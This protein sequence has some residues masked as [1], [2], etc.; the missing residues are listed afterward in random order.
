MANRSSP[1][2]SKDVPTRDSRQTR[3]PVARRLI[4]CVIRFVALTVSLFCALSPHAARAGSVTASLTSQITIPQICTVSSYPSTINLG[5]TD[6]ITQDTNALFN[7]SNSITLSCSTGTNAAVSIGGNWYQQGSTWFRALF[8]GND[9]HGNGY[10]WYYNI[11]QPQTNG[12]CPATY[13]TIWGDGTHYATYTYTAQST[14]PV[15]LYLCF[16]VYA[17]S[18]YA[19]YGA[20]GTYTDTSVT[21]TV[22]P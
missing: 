16:A 22:S 6:G 21:I 9:G 10:S 17:G 12:I 4:P 3:L 2:L 13:T 1:R 14:S 19:N 15:T 18:S 8:L 20:P 5:T 7:T 11:F